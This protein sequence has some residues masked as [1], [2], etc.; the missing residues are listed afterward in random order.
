M[1]SPA[2]RCVKENCTNWAVSGSRYCSSR[3]SQLR[4]LTQWLHTNR[5]PISSRQVDSLRVST[6]I[7]C[8]WNDFN[9][10]YGGLWWWEGL[11]GHC[12]HSVVLAPRYIRLCSCRRLFR[13]ISKATTRE[14]CHKHRTLYNLT[15]LPNLGFVVTCLSLQPSSSSECR[16]AR[17]PNNSLCT[18]LWLI[19]L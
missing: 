7:I 9:L 6:H 10:R 5:G 13:S 1:P 18:S 16:A 11:G 17:G 8:S 4:F 3:K 14:H 15:C 12:L 19:Q 2:I